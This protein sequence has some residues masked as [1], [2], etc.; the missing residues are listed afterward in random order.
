[1]SHTWDPSCFYTTYKNTSGA[2]RKFS[3]LPPFGREL[4]ANEE[5]T[6]V[7][8]PSDALARGVGSENERILQAFTNAVKAGDLTVTQTPA[9]IIK[10][11]NAPHAS[12]VVTVTGGVLGIA[13]PCYATSLT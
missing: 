13:D 3:F 12:K 2:R 9:L 6:A 11:T 4:A 10:D 5:F 1:M 8:G 7:G